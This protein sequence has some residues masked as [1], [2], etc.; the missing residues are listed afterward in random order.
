MQGSAKLMSL[1]GGFRL[2]A[3]NDRAS[4]NQLSFTVEIAKD[5]LMILKHASERISRKGALVYARD[6]N[7]TSQLSEGVKDG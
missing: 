3:F 7:G 5:G 6:E 2:L 4:C 1:P